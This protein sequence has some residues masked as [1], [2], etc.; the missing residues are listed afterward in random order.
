MGEGW[1]VRPRIEL[2]L[3]LVGRSKNPKDFSGG[4]NL[5]AAPA[6]HPKSL[7][8]TLSLHAA[9]RFRP[10]HKGKVVSSAP[11]H[12][13]PARVLLRLHP[14]NGTPARAAHLC[15]LDDRSRAPPGAAQFRRRREIDAR[16]ALAPP[17]RR[18]PPNPPRRHEPRMAPQAGQGA[19]KS[20]AGRIAE[21][22]A[23][24]GRVLRIVSNSAQFFRC[25][26]TTL[27]AP[28]RSRGC[29]DGK[30][31]V[32]T[33][34]AAHGCVIGAATLAMGLALTIRDVCSMRLPLGFA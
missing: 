5:S 16:R 11:R 17:L 20:V 18:T 30:L 13:G 7:A 32:P 29:R 9:T 22:F 27:A 15:R 33:H 8:R 14:G 24:L 1:G 4:G 25:I 6:P 31:P 28:A 10:P 23:H 12:A 19:E 2:H 21:P 3:P 26:R 34:D